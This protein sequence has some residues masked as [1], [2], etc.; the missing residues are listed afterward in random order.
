MFQVIGFVGPRRCGKD[1]SAQY[2][3]NSHGFTR[4]ALADALKDDCE[5]LGL[6]TPEQRLARDE[7]TVRIWQIWG[8]EHGREIDRRY[9]LWRWM[10]RIFP[11]ACGVDGSKYRG[12]CIPDVRFV[13]EAD[14][15]LNELGGHLILIPPNERSNASST[16]L[17]GHSS[18]KGWPE[19]FARYQATHPRVRTVENNGT[20]ED[21]YCRLQ[22]IAEV[23]C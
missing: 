17:S 2:F 21:L 14:F 22:C 18:E 4:L 5:E 8:T 7:R 15:V 10:E 19:I 13:D 16:F 6:V 23:W 9:W 1:Q 3:M 11:V 12:V 20:V